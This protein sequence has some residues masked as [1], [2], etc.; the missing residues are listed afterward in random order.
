MKLGA[1]YKLPEEGLFKTDISDVLILLFDIAKYNNG[2]SPFGV[3]YSRPLKN[4]IVMYVAK[5]GAQNVYW[6][7]NITFIFY[8]S[9][10]ESR[11]RPLEEQYNLI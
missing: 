1:L 11:L 7:G 2:E 5:F 8:H 3:A 10:I 9:Y 4:N 6:Q